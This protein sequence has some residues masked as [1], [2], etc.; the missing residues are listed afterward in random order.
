MLAEAADPYLDWFHW[1]PP[2]EVLRIPGID[3]PIVWYG[4]CFAIG[5]IVG[6]LIFQ[7]VLHSFLLYHAHS[8]SLKQIQNWQALYKKVSE[9]SLFEKMKDSLSKKEWRAWKEDTLSIEQKKKVVE[10]LSDTEALSLF[11]HRNL[12]QKEK[13]TIQAFEKKQRFK[14]PNGALHRLVLDTILAPSI[15]PL[16]KLTAFLTDRLLWFIVIATVIGARVGHLLFY[17][18]DLNT[19]RNDPL[20]VFRV[21]E[22]GL[23]SHGGAIGIVIAMLVYRISTRD[24]VPSLTFLRLLDFLCIPTALVAVFIRFGNFINQ[25]V[26][27]TFSTVPWAIVFEAPFDGSAVIPRHPVQLYEGFSCLVVFIVLICIWFYQRFRLLD[28]LYSGLFFTLIFSARFVIEFF[29]EPQSILID[30]GSALLNM[31]QYLSLPFIILGLVL[32]LCAVWGPQ[33]VQRKKDESK[34][35]R[36]SRLP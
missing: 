35:N 15:T 33:R 24:I 5:F 7:R 22:G 3:H 20:L 13:D 9:S 10:M 12:P 25:E 2:R 4:V 29:K 31:G 6:Y 32:L 8:V 28:G 30:E 36:V 18:F 17:D 26:V 16:K 19:F 23:A 11:T 21:W 14:L 34:R 27:G 1:N